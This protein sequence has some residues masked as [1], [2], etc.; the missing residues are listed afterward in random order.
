MLVAYEN[1]RRTVFVQRGPDIA[2]SRV[3]AV[4]A[5]GTDGQRPETWMMVDRHDARFGGR[6]QICPQPLLLG[7]A[8]IQ[9]DDPRSPAVQHDDVPLADVEAVVAEI[10][11]AHSGTEVIE[12]WSRVDRPVFPVP[13]RCPGAVQE[14][15]PSR[16][17]AVG[18]LLSRATLVDV[19]ARGEDRSVWMDEQEG[20][21]DLSRG[22]VLHN[23]T[24]RDVTRADPDGV[25]LVATELRP[26][27]VGGVRAHDVSAAGAQEETDDREDEAEASQPAQGRGHGQ[28]EPIRDWG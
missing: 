9:R 27:R 3:T 26:A 24:V 5:T 1:Q 18:V 6:G 19:V 7:R 21:D 22:F 11:R 12:R 4:W 25:G 10:A 15:S 28:S 8:S 14:S 13:Q 2:R 20:I 17:V 23:R 16:V